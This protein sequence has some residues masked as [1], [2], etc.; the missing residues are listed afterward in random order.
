MQATSRQSTGAPIVG[1]DVSVGTAAK[2]TARE[3][4]IPSTAQV[5][6]E[7]TDAATTAAAP[8]Q[9][10]LKQTTQATRASTAAASISQPSTAAKETQQPTTR[11]QTTAE[12]ETSSHAV[13]TKP[14]MLVTAGETTAKEEEKNTSVAKQTTLLR[15]VSSM[16]VTTL[17]V[18]TETPETTAVPQKVISTGSTTFVPG[19]TTQQE[20]TSTAVDL[21]TM[22][23]TSQQS[24]GA[25]FVGGDVSVGTADKTTARESP[26]PSTAQVS[27][28]PTDAAT[29]AAAP[30]QVTLK[31]TTQ[32]TRASTAAASISQ[33][34]TAAKE[35]QQPT[36]RQQTTAERETSSHAV[37]TKPVMLVTSGETTAKEEEKTT[38]VAKQTTLVRN[39]SSV[40]VTTVK[41][42]TETPETTAVP[43]KTAESAF[44][45]ANAVDPKALTKEQNEAVVTVT[46]AD[47]LAKKWNSETWEQLKSMIKKWIQEWMEKQKGRKRRDVTDQSSVSPGSSAPTTSSSAEPDV[48]MV[49]SLSEDKDSNFHI[50][51]LAED[52]KG[53][54]VLAKDLAAI[55]T[56]NKD[57]LESELGVKVVEVSEGIM[58]DSVGSTAKMEVE[59]GSYVSRN[60]GVFIALIVLGIC[61]VF[62]IVG[63][64]YIL[65]TRRSNGVQHY[66]RT[67][68]PEV[69]CVNNPVMVEKV[70][71]ANN[72]Q[73][74]DDTEIV[75]CESFTK[76]EIGEL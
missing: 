64:L 41:V 18:T 27:S 60:K 51:L 40:A 67:T 58:P 14:V 49:G 74:V 35:T 47:M 22:H 2:T 33:P 53:G 59:D 26:I 71:G 19:Q 52:G 45:P 7:P 48:K 68:D 61:L 50:A 32:A 4:P 38:S 8:V 46:L 16:A 44:L 15:N 56:D 5:S 57:E 30:V 72:P 39:V 37:S 9:V 20:K 42:T 17:K 29:T 63:L 55:I 13:S 34:S 62:L 65:C 75:P 66:V 54:Y 43:E 11:Q 70:K 76:E 31:Q 10:T 6:S 3:S 24:T 23:A 28:E 73:K 12:R 36:T 69:A 1:G 25:P 21:T